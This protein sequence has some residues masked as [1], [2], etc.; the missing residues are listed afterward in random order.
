MNRISA[1]RALFQSSQGVLLFF[2][3]GAK[4]T[5]PAVSLVRIAA[6]VNRNLEYSGS[7]RECR[8][9]RKR[10]NNRLR[11]IAD[12]RLIFAEE[13]LRIFD[14]A[15]DHYHRGTGHA[16]KEQDLQDVHCEQSDLE[17]ENDC[18][19]DGRG[20][21]FLNFVLIVNFL[22]RFRGV[23]ANRCACSR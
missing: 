11:R 2:F 15:D 16:H 1:D 12:T 8:I 21:P 17:H 19:P 4:R 9:E 5:R 6:P 3:R 22:F 23:A 18:I 10:E 13:L 20:I 7:G 14:E